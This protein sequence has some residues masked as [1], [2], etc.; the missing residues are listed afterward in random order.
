MMI[1]SAE[2]SLKG[3]WVNKSKQICL[4]MNSKVMSFKLQVDLIR[5]VLPWNKVS[6]QILELD[7]SSPQDPKDI[8]PPEKDKEREDLSEVALL[9][10]I[11][12][13]F[14]SSWSKKEIIKFQDWPIK[15]NLE[16]LV[17]KELPKSENFSE[18]KRKKDNNHLKAMLLLK[19]MLLEE[20]SSPRKI[21]KLLKE[22]KHQKFKD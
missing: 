20:L 3:E 6:F 8:E 21:L 16:D 14:L 17:Q 5:T 13:C 19:R 12:Q 10:P 7:F 2:S 1:T 11:F 18:L 22:I 4:V 15:L 9:V